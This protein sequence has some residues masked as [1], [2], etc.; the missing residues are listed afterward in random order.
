LHP[1]VAE[2]FSI[3]SHGR[4]DEALRHHAAKP[5]RAHEPRHAFTAHPDAVLVGELGVDVRRAVD[6]ARPS[7]DLVDLC[8]EPRSARAR[9]DIGRRSQA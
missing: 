4:R 7:M 3:G 2:G 5:R 8:H 9:A 1:I 6:A